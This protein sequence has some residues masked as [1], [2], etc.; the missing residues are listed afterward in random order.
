MHRVN[1]CYM[2][3]L[4]F[5][6]STSFKYSQVKVKAQ[7]KAQVFF[8]TLCYFQFLSSPMSRN[9]SRICW[10]NLSPYIILKNKIPFSREERVM[11]Q[12]TKLA[13][14]ISSTRYSSVSGEGCNTFLPYSSTAPLKNLMAL[15]LET[16]SP[17][18]I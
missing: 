2:S 10:S 13:F 11:M 5:R 1:G 12:N 9:K 6:K 17:L 14:L 15:S 16:S 4:T 3:C 18:R 7:V 8:S